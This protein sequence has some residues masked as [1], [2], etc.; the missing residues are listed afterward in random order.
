M[1]FI[2][3]HKKYLCG[4]ISSAMIIGLGTAVF[5][6]EITNPPAVSDAEA[7]TSP[8]AT[9]VP[10]ASPENKN[11]SLDVTATIY[12]TDDKN[13]YKV[14]FKTD[15]TLPQIKEFEFTATFSNGTIKNTEFGDSFNSNGT[16]SKSITDDKSVKFSWKDGRPVSG[17][18]ILAGAYV[19]TGSA[20]NANN[21][22]LD[23]FTAVGADGTNL[24]IEPTL[25]TEKGVNMPNLNKDEQEILD[26]INS[27]PSID[28]LTFYDNKDKGTLCDLK[29]RYANPIN[30]VLDEYDKLSKTSRDNINTALSINGKSI[31]DIRRLQSSVEAMQ[32]VLGIVELKGCYYGLADNSTALNYQ[33]LSE[34]FKNL[35]S[36]AP[37][38]LNE[39]PT[40]ANEYNDAVSEI[41][42][43]NKIIDKQTASITDKTYENYHLRISALKT[44]FDNAKSNS[45][46]TLAK[47]LLSSISMLADNLYSDIETNYTGSYKEYMLSDI[48]QISDGIS[49]G[50]AIYKN[51]PK[52]EFPESVTV[53][54]TWK[55]N[56]SRSKTLQT[57]DAKIE[58]YIYKENGSLIKSKTEDFREGDTKLDVSLSLKNTESKG[59][60]NINVKCYYV[61]NNISYLLDSKVIKV[62][63]G[64]NYNTGGSTGGSSGGSTNGNTGNTGGGNI[65]PVIDDDIT[66]QSTKA[67]SMANDNPY[68]DIDNYDW[69][70]DAII[71][72]TNA[73][74]V[75]G[76]GD[77]EFNPAGNVT[78]EQFCKMV[79][80]LFGVS[81]SE[82]ETDFVDVN[83]NA[84][85]APYISAAVQAGYVQGQSDEY[86]G[87]GEVI[88]RQDMA[89]ILYRAS[90]LSGDGTVLDF[91]DTNNIA[92][93][94]ADAVSELVG[95]GVMNGYSDG[96]FN[97]RGSATRAEAAKVIW[98]IYEIIK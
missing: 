89:T 37:S 47:A 8:E 83:K 7:T 52:V 24:I 25:K 26:T 9:S 97:P 75:N 57:Q 34:T 91:T 98:G 30:S 63:P 21:I 81:V 79:V 53:G 11:I 58:V 72:L 40:A 27:L 43:Y 45:Q 32:E 64:R 73:G 10:T 94:A 90:G 4:L 82:T 22:S 65:Y 2:N 35:S 80:Q 5:A 42:T 68:T 66:P 62:K 76:M 69:A 84:W 96:S 49:S 87:I 56:V 15:E 28:D 23:S 36:S 59:N 71:G 12:T 78:R 85:Y 41:N 74:I 3:K 16:T 18:V 50:D 29:L 54:Y 77:N 46:I 20:L 1:N 44:Q 48:R 31:S 55:V 95:L 39:A 51:M 70:H 13:V 61:Y 6:D 86:F 38:A 19:E 17:N 88:M 33:Y 92:A 60:E 14:M 93:Y 67:P